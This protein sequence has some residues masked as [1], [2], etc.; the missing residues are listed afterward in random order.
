MPPAARRFFDGL[1]TLCALLVGIG[2]WVQVYLIG[3]YL[4]GADS[5]DAHKDTGF[6]VHSLE[7]LCFV[8]ALLA[9]RSRAAVGLAFGLGAIG[10]VQIALTESEKY[11]GGLHALLALVVLVLAVFVVKGG[12]ERRKAATAA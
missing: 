7:V 10:T 6:A 2:V 12:L 1:S 8:A 9:W 11:V 3:S 5:L 4:F